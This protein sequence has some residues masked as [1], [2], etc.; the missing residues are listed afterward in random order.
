MLAAV[1]GPVAPRQVQHET[2]DRC[3]VQVIIKSGS[4]ASGTH[5]REWEGFLTRIITACCMVQSYPRCIVLITAQI[6]SADGSVLAAILHAVVSALM[7]AGIAMRH[8]PTAVTCLVPIGVATHTSESIDS[9]VITAPTDLIRIDPCQA[10]EWEE[11]AAPIVFVISGQQ[12]PPNDPSL[13]VVTPSLLGCHSA[14]NLRQSMD[15]ILRCCT[16]ASRVSPAI[17]AFWR[18]AIESK[19]H[20]ESQTLWSS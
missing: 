15:M 20:R 9:D 19:V 12:T 16:V 14:A 17:E 3:R 6:I 4:T 5:E 10:E 13:P 8:L 7:D 2:A 1:H 18:V 11:D